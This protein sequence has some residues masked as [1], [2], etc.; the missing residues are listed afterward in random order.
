MP[1]CAM[2]RCFTV[3]CLNTLHYCASQ[4]SWAVCWLRDGTAATLLACLL[5]RMVRTKHH[6][7]S[8]PRWRLVTVVCITGRCQSHPPPSEPV[9][10]HPAH[11]S[12]GHP[13]AAGNERQLWTKQ[14]DTPVSQQRALHLVCMFSAS[15]LW[16]RHLY[17][18]HCWVEV[19]VG[20]KLLVWGKVTE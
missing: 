1:K 18:A 12:P 2:L 14:G 8:G 3:G 6:L 9:P 16:V 11:S 20:W 15:A 10:S 13:P 7:C 19:L 4:Y 5:Y 17:C